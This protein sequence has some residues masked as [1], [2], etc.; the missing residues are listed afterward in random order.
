MIGPF[1]DA[2]YGPAEE[3]MLS[4][5]VSQT[6]Q[7]SVQAAFHLVRSLSGMYAP[8]FFTNH[9]F[10]TSWTG[11]KVI[12]FSFVGYGL[13]TAGLLLYILAYF[14][15]RYITYHRTSR[16]VSAPSIAR[17]SAVADYRR[18]VNTSR[19]N[20]DYRREFYIRAEQRLQRG[21]PSTI[22]INRAGGRRRGGASRRTAERRAPLLSPPR[23][24]TDG[25]L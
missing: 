13:H 2:I 8:L 11:W 21:D 5:Q 18:R 24:T 7:A 20:F 9:F 22:D 17:G 14:M 16:V 12:T 1:V 23:Q 25:D 3:A 6:E 4:M 15:D 10:N 19:E